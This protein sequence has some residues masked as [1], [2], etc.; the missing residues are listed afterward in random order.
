MC[1]ACC[2]FR[3]LLM[4]RYLHQN[5][6]V[7]PNSFLLLTFS[8]AAKVS[9]EHC[10]IPLWKENLPF[11]QFN[12][13][14]SCLWKIF[15]LYI[16]IT[17][18]SPISKLWAFL[19]SELNYAARAGAS[20]IKFITFGFFF[21]FTSPDPDLPWNRE[22]GHKPVKDGLIQTSGFPVTKPMRLSKVDPV[23]DV[24][25]PLCTSSFPLAEFVTGQEWWHE[26]AGA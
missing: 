12:S 7:V 8:V 21:R 4:L 15:W 22:L 23:E 6:R 17:T 9:V 3:K 14:K 16:V 11:A 18:Y 2:H 26:A 20:C 1:H 10:K 25:L 24:S 19:L 13:T 5:M